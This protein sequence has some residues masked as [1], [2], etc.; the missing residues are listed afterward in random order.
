MGIICRKKLKDLVEIF[1]YG[2]FLVGGIIFVT[3]VQIIALML[4]GKFEIIIN[5][6][7]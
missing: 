3:T 5:V 2:C 6:F 7:K 1:K 4:E